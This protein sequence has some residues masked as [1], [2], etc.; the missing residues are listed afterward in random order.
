[1]CCCSVVITQLCLEYN[2]IMNALTD[3]ERKL[4]RPLIS[5][6][7]RQL[8]P[9]IYKLTFGAIVDPSDGYAQWLEDSM[10][11]IE[12]LRQ[13]VEIYKR[14]NRQVVRNCEKICDT[15]MI[16]LSFSGAVEISVFEQQ[17]SNWLNRGNNSL[18]L[19]YNNIVELMLAVAREFE[20]V[21]DEVNMFI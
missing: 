7:D 20:D 2:R 13:I 21:T 19:H 3:R 5:S 18:R 17:L 11:H 16:R 6:C 15:V 9:G 8:A 4:L 14:A 1:V 10:Q 12:Y